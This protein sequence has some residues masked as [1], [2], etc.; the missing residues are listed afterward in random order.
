MLVATFSV[1]MGSPV[2]SCL[3]G[4]LSEVSKWIWPG[5]S[6]TVASV[7]GGKACEVLGMPFESR[8]SVSFSSLVFPNTRLS[9]FQSQVFW[10]FVFLVQDP[11][12]RELSVGLR[13]VSPWGGTLK[14]LIL[15]SFVV[16]QLEEVD[17]D[18][19]ASLPLISISLF[20]LLYVFSCRRFFML[21]L[22]LFS[23]RIAL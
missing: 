2:A 18:Y 8:E 16:W 20:S 17:S 11:Q 10:G 9:G 7:L 21:V 1:P 3:S 4:R 22:M 5:S 15:F 19:M 14:I 6:Q 13:P 12:P 23:W